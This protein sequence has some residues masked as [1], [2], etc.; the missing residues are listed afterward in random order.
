MLA[1]FLAWQANAQVRSYSFSQSQ[2][3]YAPITGG[4]VVASGGAID[5]EEILVNLPSPFKYNNHD[6]NVVYFT[7]DGVLI[8]GDPESESGPSGIIRV[9]SRNLASSTAAAEMRWQMAGNEII[10][11][12]K[13]MKRKITTTPATVEQL[14]FQCRLNLSTNVITMVY[15]AFTDISGTNTYDNHPRI[16]LQ[17]NNYEEFFY[18]NLSHRTPDEDPSW[19]DTATANSYDQNVRLT[20]A[21]PAAAPLSGQMYTWTPALTVTDL[22]MAFLDTN[23]NTY[24]NIADRTIKVIVT[25]NTAFPID[26]TEKNATV[27]VTIS[28]ASSQTFTKVISSGSLERESSMEITIA[29]GVDFIEPGIHSLAG[30]IT[31]AGDNNSANDNTNFNIHVNAVYPSPFV[32][33]FEGGEVADWLFYDSWEMSELHGQSSNGISHRFSFNGASA[34]LQLPTVGPVNASDTFDFDFRVVSATNYPSFPASGNWGKFVITISPDCTYDETI[35]ATIDAANFNATTAWTHKRFPLAAYAGKNI[36]VHIYSY[37]IIG[38]FFI[39]FDNFTIMPTGLPP[40]TLCA[41]AVSPVNNATGLPKGNVALNWAAATAGTPATSYDLYFGNSQSNMTFVQNTTQT[42]AVVNAAAFGSTYYW[43]VIAKSVA[44][45]ATD[46]TTWNFSVCNAQTWFQDL[47]QDTYGNGNVSVQ[48]CEQPAGYVADATD[49]DDANVNKHQQFT[50]YTDGDND[51]FG[52]D[53]EQ[54]ACAENAA[55]PPTGYSLNNTDCDDGN[56]AKH[57]VFPFFTD[58]DGDG[59]GTGDSV[60]ICAVNA[61][62]PPAGYA[63]NNTDC[64]DNNGLIYRS[65]VLYVDADRDRYTVGPGVIKCYGNTVPPGFSLTSLGEDCNDSNAGMHSK[66]PFYADNDDD[67]YGAGSLVDACSGSAFSAPDGYALNNFDCDDTDPTKRTA[68]PFYLDADGDGFGAGNVVLICSVNGT[69]PP[70]G[71]SLN[72][73]DCDD[74]DSTIYRSS[75]LYADADADGYTSNNTPFTICYGVSVPAGY[76]S[77][78]LGFDC[79]D[80]NASVHTVK[81]L[82]IDTDN[83][84]YTIGQTQAVCVGNTIPS[85]YALNPKGNDCD[86]N[87]PQVHRMIALF[88]DQDG[89][90]FSTTATASIIC[91]GENIPTGYAMASNG[92][93]C[94]DTNPTTYPGAVEI[95][96]DNIDNNC[97]GQIDE[98]TVNVLTT[99]LHPSVCGMT[100]ATVN[101]LIRITTVNSTITGYRIKVANGNSVQYIETTVPHF[102]LPMLGNYDYA[103]TYSIQIMLQKNGNWLGAYGPVCEVSSPAILQENGATQIIASQ[104]GSILPK[105]NTL[106]NTTS[107]PGVTGYRFRFT[108][109]TAGPGGENV[110]QVIDR[111]LHWMSLQML[112]TYHYN[113]TYKVEVA[114]KTTGDY[115]AYGKPCEI[116]SPASVLADCGI[117]AASSTT[118]IYAQS[119]NGVTKYK[120][121]LTKV[122]D[123][124]V[125]IVEKNTNYFTFDMVSGYGRGT[126]YSV[127]VAVFT[128]NSWSAFGPACT[129]TAPGV[130]PSVQKWNNAVTF[131]ASVSP[132]PYSDQFKIEVTSTAISKVAVKIYDMTGRLVEVKTLAT[133]DVNETTFGSNYPAGVYNIIVTQDTDTKVL[134]IVKR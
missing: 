21:F 52:S 119:L 6:Y 3:T 131:G 46:C 57:T 123:Q 8:L 109:M 125:S 99:Q 16:G 121:E 4:T 50:F 12:W 78:S 43:K 54:L 24:C 30:N 64:D 73:T 111:N 76:S 67:G 115:S 87:N 32:E 101:S 25:N 59:F 22:G 92:I 132:N 89:D 85:G 33:T 65:A 14:N 20:T 110:V 130:L 7:A 51:G 102:T 26:F 15:G 5:S 44:G 129:L 35:I 90:G 23:Q 103:K 133:A 127:R 117:V 29:E 45:A 55:T 75:S 77:S 10:F 124:T 47:D 36:M 91:I 116:T 128:G 79:D 113:T 120:F 81:S 83:D 80:N 58:A 18:R 134:R 62:T 70:A 106:I 82:Y 108:N 37:G 42:T 34:N 97:N 96:N 74:S 2:G 38:D 56:A 114:V 100:L 49:C 112:A 61:N 60:L 39:D 63:G 48:A 1:V 105:I 11:Q 19:D 104:C 88:R 40:A 28:G 95:A 13:D 31:V 17:G 53:N 71:Y 41:S 9:L 93:D 84:T 68:F 27:L 94:D 98:G 69:T 72:K 86:D 66:F 122:S 126:D 118:R 107:L